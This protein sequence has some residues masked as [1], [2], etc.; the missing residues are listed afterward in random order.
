[1]EMR[2]GE[3][4]MELAREHGWC[5]VV[6]EAL[7][8]LGI[9]VPTREH[10]IRVTVDLVFTATCTDRMREVDTSWAQESFGVTDRSGE[11]TISLDSDWEDASVEVES[12]RVTSV[13]EV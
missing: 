11:F 6:T 4:A 8:E 2:V 12:Y 9:P 7:D 3:K 10:E 1:T 13:E 5:G